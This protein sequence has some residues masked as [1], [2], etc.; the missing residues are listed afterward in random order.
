MY[1]CEPETAA[2]LAASFIAG[3]PR[4]VK[5]IPSFVDGAGGKSVLFEIWQLASR[6]LAGS[7][8]VSL[9]EAAAS[10]KLLAE[11]HRVISEGAGA[12]AVAA[13]LAG[14]GGRGPIV[15][16]VSGGNIDSLK[17]SRI[18]AGEVP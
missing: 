8:P 16:V 6:L 11:R 18:L 12:L 4:D 3:E 13:A 5:R 7:I 2:P 17:L 9:K 1:A 14:K 10:V 15:C